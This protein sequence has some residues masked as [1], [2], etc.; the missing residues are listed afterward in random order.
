MLRKMMTMTTKITT[1]KVMTKIFG[2]SS[3]MITTAQPLT[4]LMK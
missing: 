2:R 3:M 4:V 1:L